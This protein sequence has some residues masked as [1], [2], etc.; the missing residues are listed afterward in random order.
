MGTWKP[1]TASGIYNIV[2]DSPIRLSEWLPLVA[3]LEPRTQKQSV[4]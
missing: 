1:I 2:D 4:N 3:K